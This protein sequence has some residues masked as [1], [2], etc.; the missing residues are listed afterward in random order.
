MTAT[1]K[2]D[3]NPSRSTMMNEL[4]MASKVY[5][6]L[7]TDF[8]FSHR[9]QKYVVFWWSLLVSGWEN[10]QVRA[11]WTKFSDAREPQW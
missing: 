2:K 8:N 11:E 4:S 1:S 7:K 6:N 9:A 5:P 3:S 10:G